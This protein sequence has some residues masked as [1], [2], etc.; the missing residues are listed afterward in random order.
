MI[1]YSSNIALIKCSSVP[2]NQ[3][4]DIWQNIPTKDIMD[5]HTANAYYH[6]ILNPGNG[7]VA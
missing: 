7:E 2:E 5:F 6:L 3:P 4:F 1:Q